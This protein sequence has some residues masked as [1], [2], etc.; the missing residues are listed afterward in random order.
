VIDDPETARRKRALA[1][2]NAPDTYTQ[3]ER[4]DRQFF[5]RA[6]QNADMLGDFCAGDRGRDAELATLTVQLDAANADRKSQAEILRAIGEELLI[7]IPGL[8][9][10]DR[11]VVL[12]NFRTAM[13]RLD[14]ANAA[15]RE[16]R[17]AIRWM[18]G[19]DEPNLP[20]F[21][22]GG[23]PYGWRRVSSEFPAVRAAMEEEHD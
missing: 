19:Y 1:W 5:E 15:L 9:G 12:A 16:A 14:A 8:R 7:A 23:K 21:P 6:E 13:K 22:V 20:A 2:A 10:G 17:A 3:Q 4:D 11:V 18:H